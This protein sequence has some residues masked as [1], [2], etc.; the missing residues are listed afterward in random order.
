MR[1]WFSLVIVLWLAMPVL[2]IREKDPPL[3]RL[4]FSTYEGIEIDLSTNAD[5]RFFLVNFWAT[6]SPPS[7]I[8]VAI[9]QRLHD[10]Y[11]ADLLILGINHFDE[12]E[13]ARDFI[14]EYAITY[15]TAPDDGELAVAFSMEAVPTTILFNSRGQRLLTITAP[16][17]ETS[18]LDTLAGF[19]GIDIT[20]FSVVEAPVPPGIF[21]RYEDIPF[22]LNAR[23]FPMLGDPGAPILIENFSS[24]SCRFCRNFHRD[25]FINLIDLI[26]DQDISFVYVP[27]Y[28]TGELRNGYGANLSAVCAS[29]Q[30]RFFEYSELLYDWHLRFGQEAYNTDRLR[31]GAIQIGLDVGEW[32]QCM[33]SDSARTVLDEGIEALLERN[34]SATPTIFIN[35]QPVPANLNA[36]RERISQLRGNRT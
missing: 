33:D 26:R 25:V 22:S 9:L 28:V 19:A 30:G 3:P 29:Q 36:I 21:E 2:A 24:Y 31:Q 13:A 23:G 16:L 27:I 17:D 7:L 14:R 1:R 35:G 10:A 4:V 34:I 18:L 32:T 20:L 12:D 5:E 6:W 11:S 15:L 8:D